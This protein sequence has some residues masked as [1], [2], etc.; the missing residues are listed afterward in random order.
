MTFSLG[1]FKAHVGELVF[2]CLIAYTN[3]ALLYQNDPGCIIARYPYVTIGCRH[4]TSWVILVTRDV[5]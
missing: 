5:I 3:I 4:D 2:P 1:R